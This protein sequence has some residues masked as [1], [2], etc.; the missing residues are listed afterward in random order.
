[1]TRVQLGYT[2]CL[3]ACHC[4]NVDVVK[5]L[6]EVAE[7]DWKADKVRVI[8]RGGGADATRKPHRDLRV[9][10]CNCLLLPPNQSSVGESAL[11][12]AR[13]MAKQEVVAYLVG[14]PPAV[15]ISRRHVRVG[16]F[17]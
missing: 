2:A 14:Q 10:G 16:W 7:V 13:R 3:R 6:V 4:G 9:C 8:R 17:H 12:I 1:M 11:G 15:F 5:Y